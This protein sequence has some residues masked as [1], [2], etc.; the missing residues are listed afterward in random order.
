MIKKRFKKTIKKLLLKLYVFLHNHSYKKIS[1]WAK[2]IEGVHPKHRIMDYQQFFA[3]NVNSTDEILDI[4]H[5]NGLLSKSI[6]KKAKTVIGIDIKNEKEKEIIAN[7][8]FIKGDATTYNFN[9]T[10]DK[11][12]LSNVLE[13]IEDRISFLKKLHKL[14]GTILIRVPM[15]NR[16]WITVYKKEMGL[17][18]R[19]DKTHFIEYTLETLKEELNQSDWGL[20]SYRVNWGE[21]WG[22][23]KS[24]KQTQ[25]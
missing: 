4:G 20:V 8:T 11:I 7:I 10:F 23:L 19:L 9:K 12:I 1:K 24:N 15:E 25:T 18:Y 2:K 16:D 5:G 6:A 17:E 13:H 21:L 22:E 14:S 3:D